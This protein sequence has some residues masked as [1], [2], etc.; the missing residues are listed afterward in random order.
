[1]CK[2]ISFIYWPFVLND[3]FS[4][5]KN[6]VYVTTACGCTDGIQYIR[7][8]LQYFVESGFN[9]GKMNKTPEME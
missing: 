8:W 6:S 2:A 9:E 1:M 3:Y 7:G 4:L 5:S